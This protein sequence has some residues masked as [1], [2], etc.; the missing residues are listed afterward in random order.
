M[1]NNDLIKREGL[2]FVIAITQL[3]RFKDVLSKIRM[4]S[5]TTFSYYEGGIEVETFLDIPEAQG[6]I[7]VYIKTDR[8]KN[9]IDRRDPYEVAIELYD[10]F[11]SMLQ[12]DYINDNLQ[13]AFFTDHNN[14]L[15]HFLTFCYHKNDENNDYYCYIRIKQI[16]GNEK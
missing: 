8:N 1:S 12:N 10:K 2:R 7:N 6:T 5:S 3:M 16:G 14:H 15:H 13:N 9:N 11:L 4:N